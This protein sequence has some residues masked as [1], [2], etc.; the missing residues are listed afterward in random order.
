[1]TKI[2]FDY[3]C[4]VVNKPMKRPLLLTLLLI[5]S[6]VSIFQETK[7]QTPKELYYKDDSGRDALFRPRIGVG[8]GIF[9]FFGDVNDNNRLHPYTS[10]LGYE[11]VASANL[12]RYFNLNLKAFYGNIKVNERGKEIE[13]IDQTR[14]LNFNSEMFVGGADVSYNFNHLYNKPGVI[15]PFISVGAAFLSFDTKSDLRDS[16]GLAYH[17][18]E[19]GSIKDIAENDPLSELAIDLARDYTY[20]TDL[21]KADLDTVGKYNK[22]SL[23]IPISAGID[24]RLSRRVSAKFSGTFYYTFTDNIDNVSSEGLG[25][26]KGN[27]ANDMFLFTSISVSYSLGSNKGSVK[28]NK[29]K[30]YQGTNFT[31]LYFN[32]EDGDGVNDFDDLCAKTPEGAKVDEFGCALDSDV[33][34]IH[35][36]RDYEAATPQGNIVTTRGVSLTDSMMLAAYI[37]SAALKRSLIPVIYPSGVLSI[38]PPLSTKDSIMLVETRSKIQTDIESNR[39]LD[40]L[41]KSIEEEVDKMDFDE[42]TDPGEVYVKAEQIYTKLVE[43]KIIEPKAPM[44]ITTEPAQ[45]A[46]IPPEYTDADY[47]NDGI[48]TADEVLRVIDGVLEGGAAFS[49]SQVLGLIDYATEYMQTATVVDFGGTYGVYIENTLHILDD[50]NDG[51]SNEQRYLSKKFGA[52]DTDGNGI[53]S[54]NEVNDMIARFQNGDTTYSEEQI[55]ELINLFFEEE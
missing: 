50:N 46:I 3:F 13:G 55:Y 8:T 43:Q 39:D 29:T 30:Y 21:R 47:N 27:S 42:A 41:F 16:K 12:N 22:F 17:Y 40:E 31:A 53:L 15:Q 48:L 54:P 24:F 28:A 1:M 37:D 49:V 45:P 20:E 14:N 19:D 26:R 33:D 35:N 7:G 2:E 32:D 34:D 52:A 4:S 18:Y 23:A 11:F 6:M 25:I 10:S 51:R 36:Y 5:I 9:T 44:A 38:N